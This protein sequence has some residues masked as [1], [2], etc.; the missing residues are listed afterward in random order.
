MAAVNRV[1]GPRLKN[2]IS[3]SVRAPTRVKVKKPAKKLSSNTLARR[4]NES[5]TRV[6]FHPMTPQMRR[7]SPQ[8]GLA[9]I[10]R[11]PSHAIAGDARNITENIVAARF[12]MCTLLSNSLSR[13]NG[14]SKGQMTQN[15]SA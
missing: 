8:T 7:S 3:T 15:R 12:F 13:P 11:H 10:T 1:E 2:P 14:E 9:Q 4:G 6:I 5:K